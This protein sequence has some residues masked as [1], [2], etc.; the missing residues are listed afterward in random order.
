MPNNIE[1]RQY[2]IYNAVSA[3]VSINNRPA[4]L[5]DDNGQCLHSGRAVSVTNDNLPSCLNIDQPPQYTERADHTVIDGFIGNSQPLY[6]PNTQPLL[7]DRDVEIIAYSAETGLMPPPYTSE[8]RLFSLSTPATVNQEAE[9]QETEN[10]EGVN[11]ETDNQVN[12]PRNSDNY[13]T[14]LE[15]SL[16]VSLILTGSQALI[17]ALGWL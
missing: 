10:L 16:I 2:A 7:N 6:D 11:L 12:T 13:V 5:N 17:W 9:N 3:S 14:C 15:V 4:V 1:Y 8:N